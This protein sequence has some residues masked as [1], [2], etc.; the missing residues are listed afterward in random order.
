MSVVFSLGSLCWL[1]QWHLVQWLGARLS[2]FSHHLTV[3]KMYTLNR[4]HLPLQSLFLLLLLLFI[5]FC[6]CKLREYLKVGNLCHCKELGKIFCFFSQPCV[7]R[8][9]R[10]FAIPWTVAQ[11]LSLS[12]RFPRQEYWSSLR[13]LPDPG[14]K[15]AAPASALAGRVF[16]TGPPWKPVFFAY[17]RTYVIKGMLSF[18]RLC[19]SQRI[20]IYDMSRVFPTVGHAWKSSISSSRCQ[21]RHTNNETGNQNVWLKPKR[22]LVAK[23]LLLIL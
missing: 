17:W 14:I 5:L 22:V 3:L 9:V 12:M 4:K 21:K 2:D 11:Q 6:C 7:L 8:S 16:T 13:D 15:P 18:G 19:H 23:L 10:I 20:C 1:I